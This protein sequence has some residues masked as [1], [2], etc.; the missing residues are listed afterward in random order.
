MTQEEIRIRS[1]YLFLACSRAVEQLK[2]RLVTTCA[3]W[4]PA[5]APRLEGSLRRELGMLFRYWTTRR[6][7]VRLD[8]NEADA[9]L[10][11]LALLRLFTDG[12][13]LP[14]DGS[15]LRYAELSTL[16]DEVRE[17]SH[18]IT[19][20]LGVEHPPL[21]AELQGSI[22]QWRD[23][24]LGYTTEALERPVDQ[25]ATHVK[26]WAERRPEGQP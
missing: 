11:N 8:S 1:M 18:R 2:D 24:V 19:N 6:I 14:R 3:S 9:K 25:L 23:A 13:H 22:A 12:F 15:G 26:A 5:A 7:W 16:A 4:P 10:L 20:A 21:L 17:L